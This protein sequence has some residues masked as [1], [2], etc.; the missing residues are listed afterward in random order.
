MRIA[1]EDYEALK[2][3]FAWASEH[4][5]K[6]PVSL[7][8]DQHPV[9]VLAGFEARS[10]AA[11]RNGLAL[12]IG[13]IVED[14]ESLPAERVKAIDAALGAEGVVTLSEVRARFGR[15]IRAIMK[16]GKVRNESEY[17]ALRN[18]VD[19]MAKPERADAGRLLA[20]FE[21]RSAERRA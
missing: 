21:T 14:C 17:Y 2:A 11:A 20:A 7:P 6:I 9:S 16:R 8:P 10:M 12:A 1:A 5:L 15:A 3:F 18:A 19:A 4:L 13:D